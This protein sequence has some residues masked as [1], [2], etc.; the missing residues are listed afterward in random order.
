[1]SDSILN[2]IGNIVSFWPNTAD[3]FS[4]QAEHY[5]NFPA[6]ETLTKKELMQLAQE[7]I[8]LANSTN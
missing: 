3:T 6:V 1:M 7:L 8:D 2:R 4:V 5:D